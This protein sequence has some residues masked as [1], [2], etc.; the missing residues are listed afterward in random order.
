M[1]NINKSNGSEHVS[2]GASRVQETEN[3]E[4]VISKNSINSETK[5]ASEPLYIAENSELDSLLGEAT[6][7]KAE[8]ALNDNAEESQPVTGENQPLSIDKAAGFAVGALQELC[9]AVKKYTGRELSFGNK[10]VQVYAAA[11]APVISKYSRNI[12]LNPEKI[13]LDS[14]MPEFLAFGSVAA[15]GTSVFMQCREPIEHQPE[16][17]KGAK[18]GDKS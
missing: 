14:W 11:A 7:T 8:Q 10:F 15:V 4:K 2:R 17:T 1:E 16:E 9:E 3:F 13:D 12:N 5:T 6:T 18:S